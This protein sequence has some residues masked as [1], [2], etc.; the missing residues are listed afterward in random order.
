[1]KLS[2]Q[3]KVEYLLIKLKRLYDKVEVRLNEDL[4]KRYMEE[5]EYWRLKS[6][7]AEYK[8]RREGWM[9]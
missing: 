7:E 4:K 2:R 5:I 6:I 1:M 8:A 3:G 9:P